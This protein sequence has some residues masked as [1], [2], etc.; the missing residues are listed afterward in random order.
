M[1]T[2][3]NNST[4]K[5]FTLIELLV[6]ISIV[7]ILMSIILPCLSMA[8]RYCRAAIC[9]SNIRQLHM[10]NTCYALNN[11]DFYV[12]AARDLFRLDNGSASN[13]GYHRW[14]GVRQSDGISDDPELNTFDPAKGPLRSYLN[15]G[16]V[17]ECPAKVRYVKQGSLNAFEAGCGGYGYNAVGVGSR[18]YRYGFCDKAM[19][20]SVRITEIEQPVNKIM[21]TD[22]ALSKGSPSCYIIEYS[23]C[24]PPDWVVSFG[25]GIKEIGS[26]KPSIHFRHLDKTTVVWCDGHVSVEDIDFP[27]EKKASY[28][29]TALWK[30][31]HQQ[32]PRNY[33]YRE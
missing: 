21:F 33:F 10:A 25:G 32:N 9:R 30:A 7:S 3:K 31:E 19:R 5:A 29:Q 2:A 11:N 12:L 13:G 24:E 6:V 8:R 27:P 18:S 26:P 20:S 22:T 16:K 15:D 14:H 4:Q 23:F 28:N 1:K 17:K